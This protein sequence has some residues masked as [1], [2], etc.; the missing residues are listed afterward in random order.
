MG[1]T[2]GA[3]VFGVM[4]NI[5][6]ARS[7][8]AAVSADSLRAL[9]EAAAPDP[10]TETLRS[11]LT[12][13][14]V[15]VKE[16]KDFKDSGLGTLDGIDRLIASSDAVVATNG[17]ASRS[18][19]GSPRSRARKFPWWRRLPTYAYRFGA[20][21]RRLAYSLGQALRESWSRAR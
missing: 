13:E 8:F 17:A 4:L 1:S 11:A 2:F 3:T 15:E 10:A 19:A 20:A 7:G 6:L 12:S 18:S 21:R 16:Q 9:V 14:R 5:G